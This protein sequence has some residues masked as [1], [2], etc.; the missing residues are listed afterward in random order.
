M[1]TD[2]RARVRNADFTF[3]RTPVFEDH[4]I[5]DMYNEAILDDQPIE[6]RRWAHEFG[7]N[8]GDALRFIATEFKDIDRLKHDLDE[9]ARLRGA[10]L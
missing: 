7:H 3:A 4:R 5:I 8:E 1:Y 2:I 10:I 6:N 9:L